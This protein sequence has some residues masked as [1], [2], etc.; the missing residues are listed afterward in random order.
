MPSITLDALRLNS[1]QP[2]VVPRLPEPV[3]GGRDFVFAASHLD[4]GH[5]YGETGALIAAGA[6]LK[7]AFDPDPAKLQAFLAKFPQARAARSFDEILQDPEV[8]LLASAAVPCERAA[9][10]F[11]AMRAGK[12]YLTDKSPF[13]T[14][15]Q[16]AEA[17]RTVVATGRKYMVYYCE[18][19]HNEPGMLAGELIAQGAIGRV[20]QV[21]GF[22]PHRIGAKTSRPGWFFDKS[23]YGGILCDIGSHQCEQF[24]YYTGA[25]DARINFARVANFNN[26]DTPG[27]EDF[28]EASLVADNGASFYFRV[29][30]FTPAACRAFGDGRTFI[31]GTEGTIELRKYIDS[32]TD[33]A[34]GQVY[35]TDH[36]GEYRIAAQNT[37][38]TPFFGALILDC[39]NRS[40]NAMSQ[41]HAFKAAELSMLAQSLA[42]RTR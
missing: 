7:W 28:G 35:L 23:K 27:L 25:R 36:R 8:R 6:T 33:H 18:R 12:D 4:H 14:L 16:L 19:L 2:F 21:I 41:E 20:L 9:I 26:P 39:L 29:D 10:G 32:A 40:E 13:T 3:C 42:D 17:R 34:G 22:G 30:W 24:L 5:I 1:D 31:V 37:T 38:G 15:E 11:Q